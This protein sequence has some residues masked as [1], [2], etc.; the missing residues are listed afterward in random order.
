MFVVLIRFFNISVFF[1]LTTLLLTACGGASDNA[2]VADDASITTNTGETIQQLD[3][4]SL[5]G[6]LE[7]S[8]TTEGT[9][10]GMISTNT[11]DLEDYYTFI[12]NETSEYSYYVDVPADQN[13]DVR[14]LEYRSGAGWSIGESTTDGLGNNEQGLFTAA[15]G[16]QY[17]IK[18][19]LVDAI[20][21]TD[22]NSSYYLDVK[23]GSSGLA[24]SSIDT[25]NTGSSTDQGVKYFWVSQVT[26]ESNG[27]L[28]EDL[29]SNCVTSPNATDPGAIC[30]AENARVPSVS[31]LTADLTA[32]GGTPVTGD[33]AAGDRWDN[34]N[35]STY[36]SC[37]HNLGFDPNN[38]NS[39][40]TWTS[41][42]DGSDWFYFESTYGRFRTDTG[43]WPRL[44][45]CTSSL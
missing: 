1:S 41:D 31:E 23:P 37:M 22:S 8:F 5:G 17:Q 36:Q 27:G 21:G 38:T 26:C 6:I 39:T 25:S 29:Y 18:L 13:I 28:W 9:L 16:A 7:D 43:G 10:G 20:S 12:A 30:Q 19:S 2:S 15:Q 11:T 33:D 34:Y 45:Y 24:T 40:I 42:R 32:C 14:V 4:E 44:F 35:N 3:L